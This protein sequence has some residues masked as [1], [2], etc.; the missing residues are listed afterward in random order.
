M[1]IYPVDTLKTATVSEYDNLKGWGRL[2]YGEKPV[3]FHRRQGRKFFVSAQRRRAAF[4]CD[5]L[6]CGR[7]PIIGEE[8]WFLPEQGNGQMRAGL[9]G[10]SSD[11]RELWAKY[12]EKRLLAEPK[13]DIS[14]EEV[15][16]LLAS[17]IC[18]DSNRRRVWIKDG[19]EVAMLHR[20]SGELVVYESS[21]YRLRR[22]FTG[23]GKRL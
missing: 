2:N 21:G 20:T 3:F 22:F 17:S 6:L 18:L 13:R 11:L 1:V 19:I 4:L 10:Y 7:D 9:W 16:A 12:D 8:V 5:A 23:N 15:K 14:P